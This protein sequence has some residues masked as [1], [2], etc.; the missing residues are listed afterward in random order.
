MQKPL[1]LISHS[2]KDKEPAIA[3]ASEMRSRGLSVWIDH[4]RIKFGESIPQAIEFGLSMC[5]C[6]ITV[7]SEAFLTS[8]W[9]RAEYEPLLVKEIEHGDIFVVPVLIED[10][11]MPELL[12]AKRYVDLRG[13]HED[14]GQKLDELAKQVLEHHVSN[15]RNQTKEIRESYLVASQVE[16]LTNDVA[17]ERL[18]AATQANNNAANGIDLLQ[19]VSTLVERFENYLD[20]INSAVRES[21]ID[22]ELYGSAYKISD[23]RKL[24]INRKLITI[25]NEMRS[26]CK[27]LKGKFTLDQELED[28]LEKVTRICAQISIVEDFL[29]I[30]L[31][32]N[33]EYLEFMPEVIDSTAVMATKYGWLPPERLSRADKMPSP[34]DLPDYLTPVNPWLEDTNLALIQLNN[35][36]IALAETIDEFRRHAK[37]L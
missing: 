4:E 3:I 24:Q 37:E 33:P 8:R 18:I 22:K 20:Y 6:I 35:Y 28:T 15:P 1:V 14:N 9:C 32:D 36:R 31:I 27:R 7:I 17:F 16:Q 19:T 26:I 29:V 34:K 21:E 25:S 23:E 13:S 2:S 5:S 30:R 11:K 10:C 12:S